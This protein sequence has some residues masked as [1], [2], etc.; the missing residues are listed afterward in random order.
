MVAVLYR[1]SVVLTAR[2]GRRVWACPASV[3][4]VRFFEG[5]AVIPVALCRRWAVFRRGCPPFTRRGLLVGR[6]PLAYC[7]DPR[8]S[9]GRASRLSLRSRSVCVSLPPRGHRLVAH[10]VGLGLALSP[11][12]R[13]QFS[14]C[15]CWGTPPPSSVGMASA[16]TLRASHPRRVSPSGYS[17]RGG[18]FPDRT[19]IITKLS[20]YDDFLSFFIDYLSCYDKLY[21]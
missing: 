7:A 2:H 14:K 12:A 13:V 18:R 10:L 15:A 6:P 16:P 4:V 21:S 8:P 9:R 20:V 5:C 11:C 17:P 3:S 19:L 1:R